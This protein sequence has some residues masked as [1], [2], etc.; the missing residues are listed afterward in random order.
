MMISEKGKGNGKG[1]ESY[2]RKDLV[3]WILYLK[4]LRLWEKRLICMRRGKKKR[5]RRYGKGGCSCIRK[6]VGKGGGVFGCR[7]RGWRK[8]VC[9]VKKNGEKRRGGG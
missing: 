5:G 6:K 8:T 7:F 2:Q 4:Y 3:R 1:G 9:K